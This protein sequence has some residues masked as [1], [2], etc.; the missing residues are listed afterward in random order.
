MVKTLQI[1]GMN[2]MHCAGKVQVALEMVDGVKSVQ[3]S[4]EENNATVEMDD[5]V[6]TDALST[7]VEEVGYAVKA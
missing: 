6:T 5:A 2:C 1:E 3:V 7:A 4:L